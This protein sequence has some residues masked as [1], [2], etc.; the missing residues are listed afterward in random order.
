[1]S[2]ATPVDS[3]TTPQTSIPIDGIELNM[4]QIRTCLGQSN[5]GSLRTIGCEFVGDYV[6]LWGSVPSYHLKQMAQVLAGGVVGLER[7]KNRIQVCPNVEPRENKSRR[8]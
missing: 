6:L 5:Y 2:P 4:E 1:M 7:I 8:D 3:A